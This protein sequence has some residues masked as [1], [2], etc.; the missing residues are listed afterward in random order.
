[1]NNTATKTEKS[2]T[3]EIAQ[4]IISQIQF[5]DRSA[6]MAWGATQYTAL[7]ESKVFQGGVRFKVNGLK[8]QGF[9]SIQ[10]RW[11]DDYTVT[12]ISKSGDVVKQV[13][14][15]YCDMLVEIIDWIEGR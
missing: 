10:L 11:L 9:V 6:L 8:F 12:F 4:T 1:M 5:G 7:P 3:M 2:A 13:E 14:M 15:V